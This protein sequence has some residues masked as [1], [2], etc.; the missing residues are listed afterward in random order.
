[1][2]W[3]R[4]LLSELTLAPREPTVLREDNKGTI[5]MTADPCHAGRTR[6]LDIA[7]H[8]VREH[9]RTGAVLFKYVPGSQNVADIFTKSLDSTL[10]SR[11]RAA[12][13]S[14]IT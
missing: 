5:K 9:V 13:V 12:L 8:F 14:P 11:F 10:F 6:H 1:M 2:L 4:S 7:Y 3:L